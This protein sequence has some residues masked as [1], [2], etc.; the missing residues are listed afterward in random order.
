[1]GLNQ[2]EFRKKERERSNLLV[3]SCL[4]FAEVGFAQTTTK[5][6]P[7]Q[8]EYRSARTQYQAQASI[9]YVYRPQAMMKGRWLHPSI[10]CDGKELARIYR[11]T[12]FM[13]AIPPGSHM[14]TLGRTEVGQFVDME[15][16]RKYYFR[17]GHKN[18]AVTAVSGREALT[19]TQVN[20]AV[21]LHEMDGLKQESK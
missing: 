17:F 16:G 12:V 8:Q 11:G 18:I 13:T 1:M 15:P 5:P 7:P 6:D 3:L 19:L 21:A 2:P 14:I 4:I 10:Y 9:I 20:E